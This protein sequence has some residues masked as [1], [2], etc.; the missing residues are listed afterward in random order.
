M[1]RPKGP[2]TVAGRCQ[3]RLLEKVARVWAWPW[4]RSRGRPSRRVGKS[5]LDSKICVRCAK[6]WRQN[7]SVRTLSCNPVVAKQNGE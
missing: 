5:F 1:E 2:G 6:N 4:R 3:D 7:T